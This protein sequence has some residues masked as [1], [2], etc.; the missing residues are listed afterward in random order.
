MTDFV[1]RPTSSEDSQWIDVLIAEQWGADSVVVHGVIYH[2]RDLPG[3]VA[4]QDKVPLG[5]VTY[6]ISGDEC[7]I[8]SL[9]SEH[10]GVGIGTSLITCVKNVAEKAQCKRLWLVTTNDNLDAVGF[11][12]KRGFV[13]VK[14]NRN[15]IEHS[16]KLKP[17][18][19]LFGIDSIPIRDEIEMEMQ[20]QHRNSV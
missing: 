2:P 17:T 8:V 18:I 1:I 16:R 9:N 10:P 11:Y 3:F 4:I 19:P 7:E 6:H 12:Q 14:I 15:A 20:L 5:L 13:L